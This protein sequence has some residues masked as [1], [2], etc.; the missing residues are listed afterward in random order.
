MK[1]LRSCSKCTY[2]ANDDVARCPEC[3]SWIRKAQGIRR[4]GWLM[5][6]LGVFLVVL[7]GAITILLAPSMLAAGS[8]GTAFSGTP[9]QAILFLGLFG[10]IIVFGFTSIASGIWQIVTGRRNIRIVIVILVLAF[11]LI[12][13][14]SAA[15]SAL[16]V[17]R[18][19]ITPGVIL[20]LLF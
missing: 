19:R 17:K 6:V 16:D 3:G 7:M 5:M 9:E 14:G 4:R 18:N 8:P 15:R 11:L 1:N 13:A 20:K 12:V 10:V 2:I